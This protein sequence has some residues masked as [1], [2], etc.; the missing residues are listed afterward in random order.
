NLE[1]LKSH[2][3]VGLD[4]SCDDGSSDD[5]STG[6]RVLSGRGAFA[7]FG[8]PSAA[9]AQPQ[10]PPPPLGMMHDTNQYQ[11]TMDTIMQAYN[12]HRNAGGNTQFAYCFN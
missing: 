1:P 11:C 9:Q 10:P 7:K 12:P 8:K 6:M 3:V 5:M 2:T 4:K